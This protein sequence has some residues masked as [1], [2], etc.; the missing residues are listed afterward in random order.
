[1]VL[2][3]WQHICYHTGMTSEEKS[4]VTSP[5]PQTFLNQRGPAWS[6]SNI[7]KYTGKARGSHRPLVGVSLHIAS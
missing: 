7:H 1:M 6:A 2:V 5:C 3:V 4:G